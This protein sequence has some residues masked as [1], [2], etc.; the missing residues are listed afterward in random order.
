M[1]ERK[2][3][4]CAKA[5]PE[6]I[7]LRELRETFAYTPVL[8]CHAFSDDNLLERDTWWSLEPS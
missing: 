5:P 7:S 4:G 6:L 1:G 8:A 3:E 2:R